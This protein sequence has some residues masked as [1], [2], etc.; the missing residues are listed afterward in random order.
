MIKDSFVNLNLYC[1]DCGKVCTCWREQR[2]VREWE[3]EVIKDWLKA[4]YCINC[5]IKR[6]IKR[7]KKLR[8]YKKILD[9]N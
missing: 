3:E 6:L 4:P 5:T 9:K 7:G 1:H 2:T 8:K